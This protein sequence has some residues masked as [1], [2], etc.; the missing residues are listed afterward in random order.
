M[1]YSVC[2]LGCKVNMYEAE[3]IA[4]KLEE[5]G[6]EKVPF[7]QEADAVL[8][9]TCAVTNTAAGKSRKMLHRARRSC[10]HGAVVLV[11]CYVQV[12]PDRLK[13]ADILVGTAHKAEIPDLLE[14]F[15]RDRRPVRRISDPRRA[16]F[17]N[18]RTERFSGR[19]RAFLKIQDGCDQF[20]SYCVIPLARGHQRS[21]EPDTVIHEASLLARTHK[22]I[23][24]TGIHTGR[25]GREYGVTLA[26][27]IERI[28]NETDVQR[29]RISSVEVTEV[30][31]RL[32][33]LMQSDARIARHLHI[34]LQSGCDSVLR[35]MNRPY[36]A[37]EYYTKI[38][39]IR[40]TVGGIS[41]STD[42]I[43]G[44]PQESEDDFAETY[45]FLRKC[46]FS[47][48]HVFPFSLRSG[49][50]AEKMSGHVSAETKKIR[51]AKCLALS[52]ELLENYMKKQI[53]SEAVI[54]TET[55]KDNRTFG[56][57]SEYIPAAVSG[58]YAPSSVLRVRLMHIEEGRMMGEIL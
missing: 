33:S 3:S 45:A 14:Q 52:E 1:K 21:M 5:R 40:Q 31:D 27:I 43:V 18:L 10:P 9:F 22:E 28:L 29:L 19:T 25:Y 11:G 36:T 46:G 12:D 37:E 32:L 35:N 15:F 16:E 30:D 50:A 7:E 4:E 56:Y 47:F 17:D 6:Y 39:K 13:D 42:L 20:C 2:V 23:V 53:G 48:L 55:V 54:L 26:E 51:A 49:T 38:Q 34:P 44:F 8:V 24:L 41:I 58:A 57:T